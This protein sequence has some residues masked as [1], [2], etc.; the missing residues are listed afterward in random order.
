VYHFRNGGDEEVYIASADWMPRNLDRRVELM[1]RV[2]AA[3][4]KKRLLG[5]LDFMFDDNVK[6]RALGPDGEYRRRRPGRSEE[7]VRAQARLYEE[8]RTRA[9]RVQAAPVTLEPIVKGA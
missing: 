2:A 8:A 1:S 3:D 6:A 9:E 4:A 5:V 7:A